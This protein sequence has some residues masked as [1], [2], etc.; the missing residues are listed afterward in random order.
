ME[1]DG[2]K[3]E[4]LGRMLVFDNIWPDE[5]VSSSICISQGMNYAADS[6]IRVLDYLEPVT[7]VVNYIRVEYVSRVERKLPELL[8]LFYSEETHSI[9]EQL[10]EFEEPVVPSFV[11]KN[12]PDFLQASLHAEQ[13]VMGLQL[14]ISGTIHPFD[15]F[16]EILN[17]LHH[18]LEEVESLESGVKIELFHTPCIYEILQE[19]LSYLLEGF[20]ST[21]LECNGE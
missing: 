9:L 15:V 8:K 16:G 4:P 20:A 17:E 13:S 11:P 21:E 2:L 3:L 7:S 19:K 10:V 14:N 5:Y 1:P 18:L 6:L 12:C